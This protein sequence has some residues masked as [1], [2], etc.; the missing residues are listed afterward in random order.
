MDSIQI[1]SS[2]VRKKRNDS[3]N[4]PKKEEVNQTM[5]VN[6]ISLL[7]DMLDDSFITTS[8]DDEIFVKGINPEDNSPYNLFFRKLNAAYKFRVSY[9]EAIK[10]QGKINCQIL[11]KN[12]DPY[13]AMGFLKP[14][15]KVTYFITT[16]YKFSEPFHLN[17]LTNEEYLNAVKAFTIKAGL[18]QKLIKQGKD[19]EKKHLLIDD[20]SQANENINVIA[21]SEK[22]LNDYLLKNKMPVIVFDCTKEKVNVTQN[23]LG[24]KILLNFDPIEEVQPDSFQSD[25]SINTSSYVIKR[26]QE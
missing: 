9:I 4:K 17:N 21:T 14:S 24:K 11:I 15:F 8:N 25:T 10:K 26:K 19:I 1:S 18:I 2:G 12:F 20:S 16:R 7:N 5:L 23:V 13:F 3:K 6:E 22:K